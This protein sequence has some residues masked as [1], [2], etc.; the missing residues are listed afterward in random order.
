[1]LGKLNH[2]NRLYSF[3]GY[4]DKEST[5]KKMLRNIFAPDDCFFNSG[6]ILVMDHFG[7]YYFMDRTG[8]TF[9]Y[10]FFIE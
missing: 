1:M 2:K 10:A 7:Y 4:A 5:N 6:D 9:R 8:D 3:T